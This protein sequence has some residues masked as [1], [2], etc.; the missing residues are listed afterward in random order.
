[1]LPRLRNSTSALNR[2]GGEGGAS[3]DITRDRLTIGGSM[4]ISAL[5]HSEDVSEKKD[6]ADVVLAGLGDSTSSVWQ[7][8]AVSNKKP[9][10]FSS[11]ESMP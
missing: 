5:D 3:P 9:E 8:A 10:S 6:L 4:S 7:V 11:G 2:L 1:M